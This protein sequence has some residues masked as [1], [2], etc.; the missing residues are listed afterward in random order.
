MKFGRL[1][2]LVGNQP[3]F[4]TGLLL[5]G[6]TNHAD[7]RR[8]L[9]RWVQAGKLRQL[10]RGL[11][12]LV[13]PYQSVAP[14]PFV[15]SNA[16]MPGSYVSM[17]SALAF[18]GL[19]PE[20][21]PRTLSVTTRRS[22]Q[23]KGGFHFRHLAPRLFFGYQLVELSQGQ[24]AF[25]ATPEKALLD[26]AHLTPNSDSPNYLSQLRLQNL[27][28]LDLNRLVEFA[29]RAGKPKW[30]RVAS[31]IVILAKQENVDYEVVP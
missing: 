27:E 11:Y 13:P 6:N 16:L 30:K 23:W 9:S 4:E 18:Y 14:H 12:T 20:Y 1:L 3:L 25:I 2:S 29:G 15:I 26:L 8:Q 5:A 22:M 10:R 24:R 31:Q 19:I 17:Q 7:A 21:T 28:R